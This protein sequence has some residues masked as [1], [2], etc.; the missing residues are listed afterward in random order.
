MKRAPLGVCLTAAAA[1]CLAAETES[2][3]DPFG[4]D[5]ALHRDT[6]GLSDPLGFACST[7]GHSLT[8]VGAVDLALCA[9]PQTRSAW[10]QAHQQ[11]AALGRAESAWLPQISATGS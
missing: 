7:P 4:T 6:A 2:G 10:A 11:A 5:Q 8:F 9:N 1:C 3:P